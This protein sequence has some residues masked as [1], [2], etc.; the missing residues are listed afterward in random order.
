M[1]RDGLDFVYVLSAKRVL[2]AG[3]SETASYEV[4]RSGIA[5]ESLAGRLAGQKNDSKVSRSQAAGQDGHYTGQRLPDTAISV[6]VA[7]AC[8]Q[9]GMP[10]LAVALSG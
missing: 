8:W 9:A 5:A 3:L 1:N 4:S 7:V 2:R 6:T 10:A